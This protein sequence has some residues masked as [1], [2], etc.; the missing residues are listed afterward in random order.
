MRRDPHQVI[1]SRYVTEKA[2]MLEG[3]HRSESHPSLRRFQQLKYVFLVDPLATKIEIKQALETIYKEKKW[4][5][6][7]VNT[8]RIH[9]KKRRMR[10]HEGFRAGFKKA[11][12][13][14]KVGDPLEA[15][16]SGV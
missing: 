10:G 11:V 4:R 9:P 13:T 12:V 2:T 3:L 16:E 8:V 1:Q 15:L 5:I 6:E 7:K 14:L